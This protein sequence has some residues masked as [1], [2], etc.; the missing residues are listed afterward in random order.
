[1]N[2]VI[3][4]SS[5]K[6]S[7]ALCGF[8][9]LCLPHGLKR[10]EWKLLDGLVQQE[11]TLEK[12]ES[13]FYSGQGFKSLFAVHSGSVKTF[14]LTNEGDEQI[15]GFHMPGDL[16]G[17]DALGPDVHSCTAVA[18]ETSSVCELPIK[19]LK[20]LCIKVPDFAQHMMALMSQQITDQ[21]EMM[22]MLAKKS[23]EVRIAALLLS[24]SSRFQARGFSANQYHL[25]M[26]RHD[27]GNYLG[28]AVETV[29]R[30]LTHLHD[31]GV[32]QVDRRYINIADMHRLRQ[33]AQLGEINE[34]NIKQMAD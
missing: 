18:L 11:L 6:S 20:E 2:K 5:A 22:L 4:I 7:C 17:F 9:D 31:T 13:L 14:I 34:L 26:S 3:N 16:L 12:G 29:S 23:A 33:L 25:S 32:I 10:E 28:L 8:S 19:P 27:I 15:I 21:H 1:M 24:I 30:L